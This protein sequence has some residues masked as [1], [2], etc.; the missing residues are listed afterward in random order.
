[1]RCTARFRSTGRPDAA[2]ARRSSVI[3]R[4]TDLS[5]VAGGAET[6]PAP[7]CG[8]LRHIAFVT[9]RKY[10]H[11]RAQD[12][13]RVSFG[14]WPAVRLVDSLNHEAHCAQVVNVA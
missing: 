5:E 13:S 2:L 12:V 7:I 9:L 1:M 4:A 8:R 14:E 11:G 6:P 3:V 10:T